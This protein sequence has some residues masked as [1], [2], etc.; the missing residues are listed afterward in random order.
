MASALAL[1]VTACGTHIGGVAA[2]GRA[3]AS[4]S[5]VPSA[6]TE[7][8]QITPEGIAAVVRDHLGSRAVRTFYSFEPEP[9]SVGLMLRLREGNRA[10]HFAVNI[11][12]P[13]QSEQFKAMAD[14][15]PKRPRH[16]H[17]RSCRVLEDGTTLTVQSTAEG[18]SDDNEKG[19]VL[20]GTAVS[21]AGGARMAMYESYDATAPVS[22]TQ[23]EELL[24]DPR[25]VWMTDAAVNTAGKDITIRKLDD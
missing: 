18:F 6:T 8:E 21:K 15:P 13:D 17:A 24:T 25:L 22:P 12:S 2:P 23:L 7:P 19:G 14:C 16:R 4:S 9:G 11:Y 1:T 10:D 20:Y 5:A 3:A